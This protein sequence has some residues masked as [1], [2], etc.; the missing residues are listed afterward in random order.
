M[1]LK[2]SILN[3][4]ISI[5]L[6]FPQVSMAD[7]LDL[8][9]TA[10][11]PSTLRPITSGG[12]FK[13]WKRVDVSNK[14]S[15]TTTTR[16]LWASSADTFSVEV[17]TALVHKIFPQDVDNDALTVTLS[18]RSDTEV[19]YRVTCDRTCSAYQLDA[20]YTFTIMS[21]EEVAA[22]STG[23]DTQSAVAPTYLTE[24]SGTY[25]VADTALPEVFGSIVSGH[26]NLELTISQEGEINYVV[27]DNDD[28]SLLFANTISWDGELDELTAYNSLYIDKFT[29][30]NGTIVIR[31]VSSWFE[32]HLYV[33]LFYEGIGNGTVDIQ[34]NVPYGN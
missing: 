23:A 34:W 17:M 32:F 31:K 26:V 11:L 1:N 5:G 18:N 33:P 7:M 22:Y 21:E 2:K 3:I 16:G 6:L 27:R 25:N 14:S 8:Y 24:L 29:F 30:N 10:V 28:N 20:T 9:M 19:I 15:V 4:G 12:A 13:M